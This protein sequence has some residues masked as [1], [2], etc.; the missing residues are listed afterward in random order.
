MVCLN[1]GVG[2]GFG[3]DGRVGGRG[4]FR[5]PFAVMG[6]VLVA[7]F[8]MW[9]AGCVDLAQVEAMRS[10]AVQLREALREESRK[11][12]GRAASLPE[13]D[14]LRDEARAAA[15]VMEARAAALDAAIVEMERVIKAAR[16]PSD[17][18]VS[19]T[20][21]MLP[22]PVRGTFLL[23]AALAAALARAVQLKRGMASM[24]K[25]LEKAME[26]DGELRTAVKRNANTMR[27]IQTR[28]A[29]KIVNQ[30]TGKGPALAMPI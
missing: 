8:G 29:Q 5:W 13:G 3:S 26:E 14:A 22:E 25:S 21:P 7:V 10:E 27:S 11:W 24:A 28:T 12:E 20:A 9:G 19:V 15:G 17:P 6:W 30:A 1:R 16:E 4:K 18:V 2:L 23:G